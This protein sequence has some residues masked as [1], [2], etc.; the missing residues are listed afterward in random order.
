[1]RSEECWVSGLFFVTLQVEC[2]M[3]FLGSG[4]IDWIIK[5]YR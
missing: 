2:G 4:M 1:M 5:L 3:G